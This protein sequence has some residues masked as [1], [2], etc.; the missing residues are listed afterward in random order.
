MEVT[1]EYITQNGKK[2]H[3]HRNHLH[4]N[5]VKVSLPDPQFESCNEQNPLTT[6]VSDTSDKTQK[7][8]SNFW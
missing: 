8:L 2:F 5:Y 4:P 1:Y 6:H 3:T 7:D